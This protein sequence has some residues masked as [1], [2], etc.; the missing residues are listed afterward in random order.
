ML[1]RK[2]KFGPSKYLNHT[3]KAIYGAKPLILRD[4]R[5]LLENLYHNDADKKNHRLKL[6]VA[7]MHFKM[8]WV[9]TLPRV[10]GFML[11]LLS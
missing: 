10:C 11:S 4:Y 7:A 1:A 6:M 3:K 9:L 5:I 8:R 2:S